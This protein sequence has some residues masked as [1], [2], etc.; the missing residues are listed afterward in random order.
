M[1]EMHFHIFGALAFLL[2]YRDW[3]VRSWSPLASSP[4]TTSASCCCRTAAR[5]VYVM[6]PTHLQPRHGPDARGL[7]RLRDRRAG[8][9][10]PLDGA[11]DARRRPSCVPTTPPSAPSSPRSPPRSSARPAPRERRPAKAPPAS[12]A[13]G[14]GQVA[15]LV[16]TIQRTAD[17]DH[18]R[19]RARCPP[20]PP[21]PSAPAPRSPTPSR[22][23][24]SLTEQQ[25][26][27][28]GRGRRRRRRGR[29]RRRARAAAAEA[30]AEAAREALAD[31]ERGMATA[32]DARAAMSRRRGVRRRDHRG[33]RGARPPLRRD[34]RLRRSRSRRSPSRRTCWR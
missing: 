1:I 17:G 10:R 12:C 13:A 25:A 8:G 3:R 5:R 34:H 24:A 15:T 19:P 16:Q 26:R 33:V 4:S 6:P 30:A 7:R 11:G 27:A 29:R 2:V 21:T 20:P 31:A 9:P 18:R 32:D 23:V 22:S 14:I 28:R